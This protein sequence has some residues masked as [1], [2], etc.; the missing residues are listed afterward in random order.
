GFTSPRLRWW[1][2]YSCRDDLGT[3]LGARCASG[4]CATWRGRTR[5][6]RATSGDLT[7]CATATR[8]CGRRSASCADPL[9]LPRLARWPDLSTSRT[10]TCRDSQFS[11][12]YSIGAAGP[13]R[14]SSPADHDSLD[15]PGR[16]S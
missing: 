16:D 3:D 12:K 10:P 6:S 8:W 5:A 4:C 2:E 13:P 7:S 15:A 1:V 11:R 9:L 14:A